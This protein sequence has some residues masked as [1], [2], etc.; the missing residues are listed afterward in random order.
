VE[1]LDVFKLAH[2]LALKT[3]SATKGFPKEELFSLGDQTRRAAGSVG[4]NL[5]EGAMRLGSKEY[6]QF[7][8]IARG[9]AGEVCYQLLLARDLK[10][11][12]NETY[13]EL[14]TGYDRVVQMLFC[15][16]QSLGREPRTRYLSVHEHDFS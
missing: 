8:G 15:L 6:R 16:S 14:R 9:S 12:S 2:Q 7:V 3:Y 4:M 1:D 11:I 10:Y 13:Q 5:M